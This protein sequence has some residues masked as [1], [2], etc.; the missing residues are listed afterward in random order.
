MFA[1][2]NDNNMNAQHQQQH[3]DHQ[4]EHQ[5]QEHHHHQHHHETAG[6]PARVLVLAIVI[7]VIFVATEAGMGWWS[8]STGL[9]SDAGHNLSDVLGLILSLI[10]IGLESRA[11]SSSKK[12]S[13]YITL[14]NGLLLMAAV[15]LILVESI[16]KIISPVEV[17]GTAVIVTSAIAIFIN[18]FT[19]WL[20]MRGGSDNI[21]IKA[22]F[23]HAATDMLVS[24]AVV[25]SG[26]II[27]VS[28]WN[29]V[30]PLLSLI[31]TVIIAVPTI[32]LLIH[33]VREIRA[34]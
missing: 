17:N 14:A 8:N 21:N 16:E 23:L 3:T 32:K 15:V 28:G 19:A 27:R 31:V 20:L 24:V 4:Q 11:R 18:G 5:H 29:L 26:V 22:A 13:R 1:V 33:T 2:L 6:I 12:I 30:D 7:N 25:V 9:L 10:A 34:L